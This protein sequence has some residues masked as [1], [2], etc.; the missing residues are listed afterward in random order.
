ME[1]RINEVNLRTELAHVSGLRYVLEQLE[2][3]SSAARQHLL[4]QTWLVDAAAIEQSLSVVSAALAYRADADK[5]KVIDEIELQLRLLRE[6]SSSIDLLG[7][8]LIPSDVDLFE[9]KHL[10]LLTQLLSQLMQRHEIVG[11]CQELPDL[12]ALIAILDPE[13]KG[14]DEFYIYDAYSPQLREL[15]KELRQAGV[16]ESLQRKI[17]LS[18][19]QEE[20][21]IRK[22]LSEQL[23]PYREELMQALLQLAQLDIVLAKAKLAESGSW[24]R[25]QLHEQWTSYEALWHPELKAV[26]EARAEQF[27][28]VDI[29]MPQAPTLITGAN[30]AGKTVLLQSVGLA[31]TLCQFGFF[32]PAATA[33]IV[34]VEAV[35]FSIGDAQS[36][37]DGLS[38]FGAEMLR[39]SA[40]IDSVEQGSRIL[41]LID[42]PARS[43]NPVEGVAIATAIL[44]LLAQ[45]S[46]R[47]LIVTHYSRICVGQPVR[48]LQVKGFREELLT[49]PLNLNKLNRCIDYSLHELEHDEVPREAIR[50]AEIL[51]VNSQ[52]LELSR[53]YIDK[54]TNTDTE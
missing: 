16:E 17:R 37:S 24:C 25:P 35:L 20:D 28:A 42:E 27:Q 38:S 53:A 12:T 5:L 15:R 31:Q 29:A 40:I 33:S 7:S 50:I 41:A 23:R 10:A 19:I 3:S 46:V 49:H 54:N 21:R 47:A 22:E 43:T 8:T 30:M 48:C 36:I 51:G 26:L 18:C 52:L 14:V 4:E 6:V 44:Q 1:R 13:A 39:L 9:I 2:L 11:L 32:V 45:K 34:P